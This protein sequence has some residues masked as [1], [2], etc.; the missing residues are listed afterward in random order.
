MQQQTRQKHD[1]AGKMYIYVYIVCV[2]VC[3]SF[4]VPTFTPQYELKQLNS[5]ELTIS[6][7]EIGGNGTLLPFLLLWLFSMFR[8]EKGIKLSKTDDARS[9]RHKKNNKNKKI[10]CIGM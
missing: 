2:Y 6:S 5:T 3:T 9:Y 10:N 4:C 7:T 1:M 8:K